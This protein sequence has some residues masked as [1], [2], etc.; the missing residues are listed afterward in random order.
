V[1]Y[2]ARYR[3]ERLE[4]RIEFRKKHGWPLWDA[5]DN[6]TIDVSQAAE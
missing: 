2:R 1:L 4:R 3:D 5:A 6:S